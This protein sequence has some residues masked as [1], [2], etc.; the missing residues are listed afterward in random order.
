MKITIALY[1]KFHAFYM[2]KAFE[3]KKMLNKIITSYP[4][5]LIKPKL[6]DNKVVSLFFYEITIRLINI[7]S[8]LLKLEINTNKLIINHYGLILSKH[9]TGNE[10]ILVGWSSKSLECF[11]KIEKTKTVKILERGSSHVLFQRNILREEY[12]LLGLKTPNFLKKDKEIIKKQ[13]DEYVKADFISV[14]SI[15]VRNTFINYGIP[16]NK[17]LLI[18]YGIDQKEFHYKNLKKKSEKFIIL[19]VGTTEVRKGLI[20]LFESLKYLKNI[21]YELHI[22]GEISEYLKS[23]LPKNSKIKLFGHQKQKEL[24]KFYNN[25]S[26]LIH[27][28]IEEGQSVVQIQALFCG[29]PIICTTN[30]GGSDLI[31]NKYPSG[32]EINIRSPK[33][34]AKKI[35][36]YSANKLQLKSHSQNALKNSLDFS[37][38]AYGNRLI[39]NYKRL[40]KK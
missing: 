2:A 27:P 37:I 4:K 35:N 25:A 19:Y 8:K 3:R 30:T 22:V 7:V 13:L 20:Y 36:F 28:S 10:E 26:C 15:F 17:I 1:G 33:E 24:Y 6:K 18:N 23:I 11:K 12:K 32:F 31:F 29:L 21:N 14:P 9:I 5:F 38:E 34:I 16:K 39:K 40:I